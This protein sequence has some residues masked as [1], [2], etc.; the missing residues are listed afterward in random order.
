MN[1]QNAELRRR[2][3]EG[4][5]LGYERCWLGEVARFGEKQKNDNALQ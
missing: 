2:A 1:S 3:G 4:T 5:P